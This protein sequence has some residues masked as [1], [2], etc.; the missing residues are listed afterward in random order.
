MNEL[1]ESEEMQSAEVAESGFHVSLDVFSG[2]FDALLAL[3]SQRRL[4]LT[5]V[6]LSSITD[7]FL[8]YVRRIDFRTNMDEA[9][10]F[11]DIAAIL[12]EAKSAALL[13]GTEESREDEQTLEALR[14]RDLLFARLV[15]YRAFKEAAGDFRAR[16]AGNSGRFP[17]IPKEN[18]TIYRSLPEL[19]WDIAPQDLAK[20]AAEVF[21]NAPVQEVSL[22]QLHIPLVDLREQSNMVRL[23]LQA[24]AE[25]E[26]ISFEEL[27]LDATTRV[28]IVA[29]F[30]AILAFF[31]QGSLQFKQQEAFSELRVRWVSSEQDTAELQ[32]SEGDFA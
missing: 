13:P 20:I 14:E 21:V 18:D 26:S 1:L 11:L 22:H 32:I 5:E 12:V 8:A 10:A 28:E 15:Q 4:E 9:S 30:L 31:K 6:S 24:L 27:T 2:P 17:H 7:D 19:V 23:R 29:R 3:I 25:G 16:I